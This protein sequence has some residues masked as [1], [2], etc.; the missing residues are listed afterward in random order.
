MQGLVELRR[1]TKPVELIGVTTATLEATLKKLGSRAQAWAQ[2]QDFRADAGSL[3][4]IPDAAGAIKAA[5]AGVAPEQVL[6][7]GDDPELDVRGAHAAG[8]RTAWLNRRGEAWP[9]A[10]EPDVT[11]TDLSALADWLQIPALAS[12]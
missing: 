2:A 4:L 5:L 6:H 11:F 9:H 12:D 3:C 7:V 10:V 1:A 8:L